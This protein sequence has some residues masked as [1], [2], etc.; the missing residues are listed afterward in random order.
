MSWS[1]SLHTLQG[2]G[3]PSTVLRWVSADKAKVEDEEKSLP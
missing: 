3:V 2:I 1:W